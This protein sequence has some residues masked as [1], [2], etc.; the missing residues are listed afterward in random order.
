MANIT[1][2][3]ATL[4]MH[5]SEIFSPTNKRRVAAYARVSTDTAEQETRLL[6][7]TNKPNV[8]PATKRL[9]PQRPNATRKVAFGLLPN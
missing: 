9:I 6:R 3:P 2:I 1:V 8:Y 5:H 7:S 4:A